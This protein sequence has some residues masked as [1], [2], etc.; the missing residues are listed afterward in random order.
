MARKAEQ[1]PIIFPHFD[2][3]T[4]YLH[5]LQLTAVFWLFDQLAMRNLISVL[6]MIDRR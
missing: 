1:E 2:W 6:M 3:I 4:L 5:N